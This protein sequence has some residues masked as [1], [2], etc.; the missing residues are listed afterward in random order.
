MIKTFNEI[1]ILCEVE[2]IATEVI[3]IDSPIRMWS[4]DSYGILRH[5][6]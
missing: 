1:N 2:Y 3:L 5:N 6:T 4:C